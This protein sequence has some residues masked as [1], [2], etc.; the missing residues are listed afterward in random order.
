MRWS[1][2]TSDGV[3]RTGLQV[4]IETKKFHPRV[5]MEVGMASEPPRIRISRQ[6]EIETE[7]FGKVVF[8]FSFLKLI[9]V[10]N[11]RFVGGRGTGI[12]E[13][14]A[15]WLRRVRG[16]TEEGIQNTQKKK[17]KKP[18]IQN[19]KKKRVVVVGGNKS[20]NTE[21]GRQTQA[22]NLQI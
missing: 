17:K 9:L 2:P 3:L 22:D 13:F 18:K 6:Q 10:V 16:G 8:F 11:H 15:A 4:K 21:S 14:G 5:S 19:K 12:S 7:F 20:L 1:C